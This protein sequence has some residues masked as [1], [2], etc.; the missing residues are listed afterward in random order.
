M[1]GGASHVC[2]PAHQ[3]GLMAT[4]K[5]AS[6][7]HHVPGRGC[8]TVGLRQEPLR[9]LTFVQS[10]SQYGPGLQNIRPL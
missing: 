2:C 10:A 9:W 3:P 5:T 6:L 7:R 8:F 1:A 4:N